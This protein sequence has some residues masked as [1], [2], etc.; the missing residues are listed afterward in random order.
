MSTFPGQTV[1]TLPRVNARLTSA[2]NDA[3]EEA[4]RQTPDN[5]KALYALGQIHY[6]AERWKAIAAAL[7]LLQQPTDSL[8]ERI[9]EQTRPGLVRKLSVALM[10]SS[11]CICHLPPATGDIVCW[12]RL[13]REPRNPSIHC[14]SS[15]GQLPVS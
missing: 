13:S 3:R 14:K 12:R 2:L 6:E 11:F 7:L 15:V 4:A 8:V 5:W 9:E 10:E 1:D